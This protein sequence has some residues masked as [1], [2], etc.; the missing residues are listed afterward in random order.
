MKTQ[1]KNQTYIYYD[2]QTDNLTKVA[3]TA[4]PQPNTTFVRYNLSPDTEISGIRIAIKNAT[5]ITLYKGEPGSTPLAADITATHIA[6][7]PTTFGTTDTD[8]LVIA[9]TH[10]TATPAPTIDDIDIYRTM[11]AFPDG[12]FDEIVP[13][14]T[15][16]A[17]GVI[18]LADGTLV[19]YNGHSGNKW[20]WE[21]TARFVQ[22][23]IL[24]RI[25]ALYA[26]RPVFYFAQEPDRYPH[27]IHTCIVENPNFRIPYTTQWKGNGYRIEMHI[28]QV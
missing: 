14:R 27:R 8:C 7:D 5:G 3:S 17:G 18:E 23:P 24:D 15:D 1:P 26:A 22:K 16:R 28:A 13:T 9:L 11:I 6:I 20:R 2:P 10:N 21:L 25:D 4:A 19:Q 12:F